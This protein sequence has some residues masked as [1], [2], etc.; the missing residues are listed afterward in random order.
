MN[1]NTF[2]AAF[3]THNWLALVMLFAVYLRVLLSPTSK[4]MLDLAPN[5][6]PLPVA[7]AGCVITVDAALQA[8][9]AVQT[10][11]IAGFVGLVASGFFDGLL[12]AMFGSAANAPGWAKWLVGVID[13]AGAA[14]GGGGS[15]SV[16]KDVVTAAADKLMPPNAHRGFLKA[17]AAGALSAVL[18]VLLS[19]CPKAVT[20]LPPAEACV[21]AVLA[22]A[23]AG[24]TFAQ[25]VTKDGQACVNDVGSIVTILLNSPNPAVQSSQAFADVKA[26]K[27]AVS[28]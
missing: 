16:K 10:A 6:R 26:I 1:L 24:L 27:A 8:H 15:S 23:L 22:D 7:V 3:Q 5:W 28:R 21:T 11:A 12:A 2:L 13:D 17:S 25:I 20:A 19:A 4:Y 18:V 14:T 9:Q